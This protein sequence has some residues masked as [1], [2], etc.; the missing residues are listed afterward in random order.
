MPANS[1]FT[2]HPP[3][4]QVAP[5]DKS[6]LQTYKPDWARH[7][8]DAK[9]CL[10]SLLGARAASVQ[11]IGSTAVPD[12][13]AKPIID[14]LLITPDLHALDDA[15][16]EMSELGYKAHGEYGI[17]GRRYFTRPNVDPHSSRP[18]IN[19]HAFEPGHRHALNLLLLRDYLRSN[20]EARHRYSNI[21]RALAKE[22]PSNPGAYQAGKQP[23]F[24]WLL[25]KAT[26][27]R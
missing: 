11:H 10:Q 19:L 27:R 22:H 18:L 23:I 15:T 2:A 4:K 13:A 26:G 7:F 21:K 14:I 6:G 20:A 5:G 3:S 17:T 8:E 25:A 9:S 24:D 16:L 1:E 12:M